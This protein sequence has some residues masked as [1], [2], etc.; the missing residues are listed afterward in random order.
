MNKQ[1]HMR[2]ENCKKT[3]IITLE[4]AE[5]IKNIHSD[6]DEIRLRTPDQKVQF[7]T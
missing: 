4:K 3:R 1:S 2:A 5:L 6:I 7:T